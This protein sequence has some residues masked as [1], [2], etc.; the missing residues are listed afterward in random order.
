MKGASPEVAVT[1]AARAA[2][3]VSP[4]A[5]GGLDDQRG[6]TPAL[7]IAN[8]IAAVYRANALARV[9]AKY[10]TRANDFRAAAVAA[11]AA[12]VNAA[13]R[14]ARFNAALAAAFAS[15]A[16]VR[17]AR[18]VDSATVANAA[19]AADA[20]ADAANL[21][22]DPRATRAA[23]WA[24]VRA[25]AESIQ[26]RGT[27]EAADLVLWPSGV[28]NWA[29]SALSD[30]KAALP[31]GQDWDVWIEWYEKRLR[32]VSHGED[33]ELV[34]ASVPEEEWDKG[35]AAANAWIK[36][37]LPKSRE[38]ARSVGLPEPLP[39]LDSPFTYDWN[40][41]RRVAIVAG[42]QNLP[43]F[44]FSSSEDDH[45]QTVE[46]CRRGA[47]RLLKEL[48]DG[49][50][51]NAVRREYSRRLEYYLE[52]LPNAP[53]AGNI[54]LANDQIVVLRAMLAQDDAVP[55]SFTADLSRLIDKQVALNDF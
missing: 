1:I 15:A 22:A 13:Q 16:A 10:A 52:D 50:Y 17:A 4:L 29:E 40:A 53:G 47:E 5:A 34:F 38:T 23:A 33:Y 48:R 51:G 35:A 44:R 7:R 36:A 3:R 11:N 39:N 31:I 21:D 46:A 49:N 2:L 20:S 26:T 28:P 6:Q 18:A 41:N 37:R 55:F 25:D 54:L 9:V 30:L 8:L 32:G 12:A 43:L 24:A 42:A 19:A 45:R 27:S 14:A